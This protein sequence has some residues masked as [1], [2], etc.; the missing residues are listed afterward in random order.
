MSVPDEDL[1]DSLRGILGNHGITPF[2]LNP[3]TH[4][5]WTYFYFFITI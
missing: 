3:C 2:T 1:E 4:E 5:I